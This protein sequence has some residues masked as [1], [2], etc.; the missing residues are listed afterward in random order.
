MSVWQGF[1]NFSPTHASSLVA[2]AAIVVA[3]VCGTRIAAFAGLLPAS[4]NVAVAVTV[5]S[6]I[7]VQFDAYVKRVA[8]MQ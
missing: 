3:V 7:D 5:T 8:T 6:L 1:A 4:G 2:V